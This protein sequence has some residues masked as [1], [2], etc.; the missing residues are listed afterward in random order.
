VE[1]GI[2]VNYGTAA[3]SAELSGVCLFELDQESLPHGVFGSDTL[4]LTR[5]Y[6]L[7]PGR[8]TFRVGA[9]CTSGAGWAHGSADANARLVV[10]PEPATLS[11]PALG[12]LAVIRR[13]KRGVIK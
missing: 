6:D 7:D 9:A 5:D 13:R 10:I 11:L 1:L 2:D 4:S 3:A 12:G 8:Y